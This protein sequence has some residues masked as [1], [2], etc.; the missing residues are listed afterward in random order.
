MFLTSSFNSPCLM[1]SSSLCF[2]FFCFVCVFWMDV[3]PFYSYVNGICWFSVCFGTNKAL[4]SLFT[5]VLLCVFIAHCVY[6]ANKNVCLDICLSRSC[7]MLLFRVIQWWILFKY[8]F[9]CLAYTRATRVF[10][11][12]RVQDTQPH[13]PTQ[14]C[15]L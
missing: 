5:T 10:S 15:T 4:H 1:F 8:F 7:L 3:F 14:T 9:I 2:A 11:H 6:F 13:T 12:L